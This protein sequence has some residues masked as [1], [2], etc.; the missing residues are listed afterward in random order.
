MWLSN[1]T[2]IITTAV[3]FASQIFAVTRRRIQAAVIHH[4]AGRLDLKGVVEVERI[5]AFGLTRKGIPSQEVK[6]CWV[7]L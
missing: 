4:S 5:V 3:I 6:S 7:P 2:V 1:T